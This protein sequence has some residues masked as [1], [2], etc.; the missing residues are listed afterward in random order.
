MRKTGSLLI[1]FFHQLITIVTKSSDSPWI[2]KKIRK[3][4]SKRKAIFRNTG[5]GEAWKKQKAVT[6]RLL[7]NAKEK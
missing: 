5:R 1:R 2:T 7:L 6:D 3:E 4:I